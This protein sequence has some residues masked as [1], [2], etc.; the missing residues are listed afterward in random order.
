MNTNAITHK[1]SQL[2][3]RLKFKREMKKENENEKR[4]GFV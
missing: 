2:H 1:F 3:E 4:K